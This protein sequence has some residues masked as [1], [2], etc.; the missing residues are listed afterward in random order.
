MTLHKN[1]HQGGKIISSQLNFSIVSK[2]IFHSYDNWEA[3]VGLP[4]TFDVHYIRPDT[5]DQEKERINS[6]MKLT[7]IDSQGTFLQMN[8]SYEQLVWN[9]VHTTCRSEIR[10]KSLQL[11]R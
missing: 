3:F 11:S 7:E 2:W 9:G 5:D 8:V 10:D 6:L 1:T 4:P